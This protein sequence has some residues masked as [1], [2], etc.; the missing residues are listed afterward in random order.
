MTLYDKLL[1]Q[2]GYTTPFYLSEIKF[3]DYSLSWIKKE[4]N[5][6]I[7]QDKV[8]R[9]ERGMYYIPEVLVMGFKSRISGDDMIMKKYMDDYSGFYTGIEYLN[10]NGLT[11]QNPNT[12]EIMTNNESSKKRVVY[13]DGLKYILRKSRTKINKNNYNVLAFLE[14]M[15]WISLDYFKDR[16]FVEEFKK[17][18]KEKQI[19]ISGVQKYAKYYPAKTM[20]KII[21]SGVIYDIT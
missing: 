4:M 7:K 6:L 13:Y 14:L 21:T 17:Y 9:A 1:K 19:K 8:C 10:T 11:T 2:F 20:K 3:K 12:Y 5:L 18:L 15:N 16:E